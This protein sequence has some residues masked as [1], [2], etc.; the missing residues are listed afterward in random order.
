MINTLRKILGDGET[1][2]DTE[3]QIRAIR[4]RFEEAIRANRR[5]LAPGNRVTTRDD[6]GNQQ[7]WTL[8]RLFTY[9]NNTNDDEWLVTFDSGLCPPG[10]DD[11]CTL[12]LIKERAMDMSRY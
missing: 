6:K 12:Y 3:V 7:N 5:C 2:V 4:L 9:N 11:R 1:F 8:V 10:Y